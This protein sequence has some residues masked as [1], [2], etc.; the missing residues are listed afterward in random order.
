MQ[1]VGDR[2]VVERALGDSVF[3]ARDRVLDRRVA[4]KV[5]RADDGDR[6]VRE[7]RAIARLSHPNVVP[8]FDVGHAPDGPIYVAMELV[9]GASLDRW[10]CERPRDPWAIVAAFRAAAQGL[11]AVHAAGLPERAFDPEDVLIGTDDRVRVLGSGRDGDGQRSFFAALAAALGEKVPAAIA[12]RLGERFATLDE[13]AAALRP[14]SRRGRQIAAAIV[15]GV[16]GVALAILGVVLS[17]DPP[18]TRPADPAGYPCGPNLQTYAVEGGGGT[19]GVRCV[20]V[21]RD[22]DG[23][24]WLAWYGEGVRDGA[25]YRHVGEGRLGGAGTVAAIDGG[26][27]G[28]VRLESALAGT[29]PATLT[30][31]GAVDE[32]WIRTAG[33]HR[34]YRTV[35][36]DPVDL[37]GPRPT[38]Y[39]VIPKWEGFWGKSTVCM[40]PGGRTWLGSGHWHRDPHLHVGTAT[41]QD[42]ERGLVAAD[43]CYRPGVACGDADFGE[44]TMRPREFPGGAGLDVTGV[45]PLWLVPA[46]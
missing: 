44:L 43:V 39:R 17:G 40:M 1:T 21:A 24:I 38:R 4:I 18:P 2:Y 31:R 14:P 33:L 28:E 20:L 12:P 15:L 22:P 26:G 9:D 36:P 27:D 46:E 25:R 41:F 5:I 35:F 37:C 42:G 34:G 23:A 16:I 8:V 13:V 32:V 29:V 3:A 19:R 10:L 6:V 45:W 11:A 7:A 30:I